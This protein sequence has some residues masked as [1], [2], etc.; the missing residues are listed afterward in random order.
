MKVCKVWMA[1]SLAVLG[2]LILG[3]VPLRA[4][5]AAATVS[6]GTHPNGVAVNPVTN[7]VY[8]VNQ[9]SNNVTVIDGATNATTSVAV[10]T[11][12]IVAAVNTLTNTI[13]VANEGSNNVTVIN[14][15]TNATA[16]VAAGTKP[17]CLAVDP[18]TNKIYVANTGSNNV[19][20]IDGATNAT[21]TVAVGTGPVSIALNP[22]T[23]QIYVANNPGDNI[24]VID[25]AT[26]NTTTVGSGA[27]RAAVAVNPVTNEI[28]VANT[29]NSVTVIDGATN[30]TSFFGIGQ[31]PDAVAVNPVTNK[32]YVINAGDN[33]VSVIDG[34]TN[35]VTA[36]V[37]I[38]GNPVAIAVNTMTNQIYVGNSNSSNVTVIDGATNTTATVATGTAP[39]GVGVNPVTNKIYVTNY[40]SNNVTVIDGATNKSTTVGVAVQSPNPV[41]VNPGSNTIYV[42]DSPVF[43]FSGLTEIN[44]A[45]HASNTIVLGVK[46]TALDVNPFTNTIYVSSNGSNNVSVI[47][48]A[49]NAISTVAAGTGPLGLAVNSVTNKIYVA[50]SS[51][52]NVTVVDGASLTTATVAAGTKPV[53]VAVNPV[54]NQIYVLNATSNNVTVIDGASN[55]TSTVAVGTGPQALAVNPMTNKIYVANGTSN[56]VTVIDGATNATSTVTV[57]TGPAALAVNQISNQ[58]YV[59]NPGSSNVTVINGATNGTSTVAVGTSPVSLAVNQVTNK[60]YVVNQGSNNM[61]VIDGTTNTATTAATGT[62]PIGVAVNPLTNETY[63]T[64]GFDNDVSIITEQ[65]VQPIPLTTTITPLTGNTTGSASASITFTAASTFAPNAPTPNAVYFQLD[66]WQGRWSQAT[67]NGGGSFSGTTSALL[68]GFHILYAFATDGQDASSTQTGGR[69]VGDSSPLV[70][71]ITVYGFLANPP[72]PAPAFSPSPA[73]IPFG[74][75]P[76]G[77]KSAA[78]SVTITNTGNANLT[79]TGVALSGANAAD[80][81][82]SADTCNGASVAATTTCSVSVTFTPSTAG[83]ESASLQF[84]D[85]ASGSPQNVGLTG[86]GIAPAPVF[87]PSASTL[88][89]GSQPDGV[90]TSAMTVTV[91]NTGNASLTISAVAISGT[92]GAD[93]AISANTCNGAIVAANGTCTASVTFTPSIVGGESAS[94]KFTDNATNSPQSVALTGTGVAANPVFSPSL[95]TIPFGSQPDGVKTSPMTVTVTNAGNVGLSI[96]A[97]A[98]AGAN[99]A[100]FAVS[101]NTCTGTTVAVNGTCSVSATFTPS[102]VGGESASLKFTDNAA[103]SPQSV[104]LTGTGVASAPVFSPSPA[105]LPFGSQP[106]GVKTAAMSVTITNTGNANLTFTAVAIGG[107]NAADFA[108]S[109]NTCNAANVA[110]NATCSVSATFTPSIVGGESAS[111]KFTDN[112]AG[113]PQSVGLTGTGIAAAPVVSLAPTSLTFSAQG[114]GSTSPAQAINLTNTGSVTL[115]IAAISI[116]GAN[117]GDFAQTNTCGTAVAAGAKC[118]I[119]VTFAPTASGAR[120]ASVSITDNAAGSPHTAGLTGTGTDFSI[121]IT[122]GGSSSVTVAPGMPAKYSLQVTPAGGFNTAVAITCMGAPSETT[123]M[124]SSASVTP[125]GAPATVMINITTTAPTMVFPLRGLRN[126]RPSTRLRYGWPFTFVWIL[127]ALAFAACLKANAAQRRR[128]FAFASVCGMLLAGALLAGCNSSSH[129]DP[130]TLQGTYTV[131]ITGTA[132]GVSHSKALTLIVN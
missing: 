89:F 69:S 88:P 45:T 17:F 66:T 125:N 108:I 121:D 120:A 51:S 5:T 96:S 40:S 38:G 112:A 92:N 90:K 33:T 10:G 56:N 27:G 103:G 113:S 36:T 67:N 53:L 99:S 49:T 83:A 104:A 64:N 93:F 65:Q 72:A 81:A 71:A 119:N 25:G 101:A 16:T 41:A 118:A 100:D 115:S 58:I 19:T 78:M 107:T 26:N 128:G 3:G 20:V 39:S 21:T 74:S 110:P 52:N 11:G 48:G 37:A 31:S 68:G 24:T 63:V 34:S 126:S 85:N 2:G 95:A 22:V 44:G 80:F 62:H 13:Y 105:S 46:G 98:L 84:T 6:V 130:G 32:V 7:K 122:N 1:S 8:T 111:L 132:N 117:A 28:Y 77:L 54:T 35:A 91:T 123:C 127:L 12:P 131:T 47:D 114:V 75:Q 59:L 129:H 23:N 70:G 9:G 30:T 116:T 57:G 97:V 18:V 86:T 109:A 94:L 43:G 55:T 79:F 61:T 42:I 106:Q 87:S 14:G 76:Q 29:N 15:A 50:N 82:I 4:Q 124:P 73:T 102:I 60:I